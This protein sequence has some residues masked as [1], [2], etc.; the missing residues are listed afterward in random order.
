MFENLAKAN[1]FHEVSKQPENTAA[2]YSP[3]HRNI[4]FT[5]SLDGFK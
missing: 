3:T 4:T 5:N 1:K 2:F